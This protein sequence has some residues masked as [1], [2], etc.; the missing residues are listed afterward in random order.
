MSTTILDSASVLHT[1]THNTYAQ[2]NGHCYG[3]ANGSAQY[4]KAIAADHH[5]DSA[6]PGPGPGHRRRKSGE[7]VFSRVAPLVR[8]IRDPAAAVAG[9]VEGLRDP[10]EVVEERKEREK[11]EQWRMV[12][13]ARLKNVRPL[14]IKRF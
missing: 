6:G 5:H 13:Y 10:P 4:W 1:H 7:S 12:L 3:H 8:L 2:Q 14:T 11:E 9:V